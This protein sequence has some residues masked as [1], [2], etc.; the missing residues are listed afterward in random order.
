MKMNTLQWLMNW[1]ESNCDGDWEH[2][3][4]NIIISTLD[5]PG[6]RLQ[7]NVM[8]TLYQD[9]DFNDIQIE[10]TENN[11]IYCEKKD[12]VIDCAC[13]PQNLEEMIEILKNWIEKQKNIHK[14][15]EIS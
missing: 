7:F 13:G 1:Y 9:M 5:N 8:G 11:W 12:G 14:T 4:T 15:P 10:R 2:S 6:W 3:H